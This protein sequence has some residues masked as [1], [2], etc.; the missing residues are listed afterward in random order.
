MGRLPEPGKPELAVGYMWPHHRAMAR[1]F[2]A[3]F[4]PN[5][6][7]LKYGF[8]APQITRISQ[9]P[10]FQAEVNRLEAQAE[11]RA[12]DVHEDL[13][14]MS[15]RA[16]EILDENLQMSDEFIKRSLK[17]KTAFDVLD[18][19][20]YAKQETPQKHLHLH[21]HEVKQVNEMGKDELYDEIIDLV[22]EE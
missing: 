5:E 6:I 21:A 12:V 9:S 17:T 19:A 4:R 11:N 8:S 16:A 2:V 3:G 22:E 7:A 15:V 10:L 20:G 14:H 1:D 13:K 18:R